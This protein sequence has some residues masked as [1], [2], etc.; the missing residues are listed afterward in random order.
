[1]HLGERGGTAVPPRVLHVSATDWVVPNQ[2]LPIAEELRRRGWLVDIGCP[3]GPTAGMAAEL[4]FKHVPVAFSRRPL[5]LRHLVTILRLIWLLARSRYTLVHLHGP[6]PGILGR[7]A[8]W[9]TRTTAV[10]H[11]R[12]T[13]YEG[14]SGGLKDRVLHRVYSLAE[15]VVSGATAWAFVLNEADGDDLIN[16][17]GVS[18][19]RLSCTHVGGCGLDLEVWDA[20]RFGVDEK[21]RIRRAFELPDD[22]P[23]VGFVGRIVREKG[24]LDLIDA[25]TK[26][27]ETGVDAHLLLVGDTLASERDQQTKHELKR[28]IGARGLSPY[29]TMTG[30]LPTPVEAV[31]VMSVLVL[32][33]YREGFGQVLVEA[34]ALG[35]PVVASDSRGAQHA[36]IPERTGLLVP[37]GDVDALAS[38]ILR[39]LND[40]ELA[41]YFGDSAIERAHEQLGREPFMA[42]VLDVY[43]RLVTESAVG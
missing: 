34:G 27:R 14:E 41:E 24:V 42:H 26:V 2:V 28:R 11:C 20:A 39:I 9:I 15:K 8:A 3:A 22:K 29:V 21:R 4:G 23:V 31:A 43:E 33:S 37:K 12:G 5:S 6:F 17:A 10:Y 1:M 13:F 16:K 19:N 40:P 38:A 32:P 36:V 35:V 18:R 30:D 7:I 25:F